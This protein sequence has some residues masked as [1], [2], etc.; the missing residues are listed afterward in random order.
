MWAI[1]S[2][3]VSA[4]LSF[5]LRT[6]IVK[7]VVLGVIVAVASLVLSELSQL[8]PDFTASVDSSFAAIP[9]FV[10][11]MLGFFDFSHGFALVLS[12]VLAR[13]AIRRIPFIG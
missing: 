1:L 7:F 8:L 3:V 5:L 12:A 9:G 4:S 13:F 11:Y 2:S 6:V 10:W